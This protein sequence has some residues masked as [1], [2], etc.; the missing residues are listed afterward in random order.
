MGDMQ[1]SSQYVA[2]AIHRISQLAGGT[3]TAIVTHSQGGPV[4]QW[5]L[6]FWP[7]TQKLTRAFIA[8]SP[9]FSGIEILGTQASDFCVGD[10]CQASLW[11][12]SI[13]SN[14]L[15][16]LR[17][18]DF[19]QLVPT[20]TIWSHTD[21]IVNPPQDNAQLPAATVLSVQDLCPLRVTTHVQMTVDSAAFALA[22]D[23]LDHG[24]KASISR[25][26]SQSWSACF[27]VTGPNMDIS[28]AD[29]LANAWG[30]LVKGLL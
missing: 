26:R 25:A 3:S 12:Q 27:K 21:G 14:Y 15:Q 18:D 17:E 6:R 8:L 1:I 30:S 16:A 20:T 29:K 9:D 2:Y 13:G 11:Q 22:L 19:Q 5:T 4:T 28:V 10:L 23:A 24:G 7:S